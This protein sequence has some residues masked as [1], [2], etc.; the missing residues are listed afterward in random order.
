MQ[1]VDRPIHSTIAVIDEKVFFRQ[2]SGFHS[3][4][5]TPAFLPENPTPLV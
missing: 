2:F 4:K 1:T 3:V 5:K